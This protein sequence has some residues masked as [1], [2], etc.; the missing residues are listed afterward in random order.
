M[1]LPWRWNIN[2]GLSFI[3]GGIILDRLFYHIDL[4]S[5]VLATLFLFAGVAA[6][7]VQTIGMMFLVLLTQGILETFMNT[8][9]RTSK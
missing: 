5:A 6:A 3:L 2:V 7:Y 9:K 8:S 1:P 4:V